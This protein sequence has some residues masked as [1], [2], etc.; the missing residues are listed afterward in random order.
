MR[1]PRPI[2]DPSIP[3]V[4][5]SN[6]TALANYVM[7]C[8]ASGAPAKVTFLDLYKIIHYVRVTKTAHGLVS[9]DVGKPLDQ[10]Y[11]IIDDTADV[12]LTGVLDQVVDV[13]TI[14]IAPPKS[15][16][17]VPLA[18]LVGG[19][20]LAT[21]GKYVFWDLSAG[22]YVEFLPANSSS[23]MREILEIISVGDTTLDA[24]VRGL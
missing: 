24:R 7:P 3:S 16:V 12:E 19:Y 15:I 2:S 17:T 6:L 11:A 14:I 23:R 13:D 21:H 4:A 22:F 18:L 5:L 1:A 20:D 9:G 10:D 8:S